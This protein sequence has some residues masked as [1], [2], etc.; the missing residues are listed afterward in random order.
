MT[1]AKR[2]AAPS[3]YGKLPKAERELREFMATM[4]DWNPRWFRMEALVN[5]AL[6]EAREL[7]P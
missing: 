3:F 6:K 2:D 7:K 4:G 5:A 1:E